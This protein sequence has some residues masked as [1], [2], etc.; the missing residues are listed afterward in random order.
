MG[1]KDFFFEKVDDNKQEQPQNTTPATGGAGKTSFTRRLPS[2]S[3]NNADSPTASVTNLMDNLLPS[4]KKPGSDID[5]SKFHAH[6]DQVLSTSG[7]TGPNYFTFGQM[8]T[9]MGDLPDSAKY[10]GAFGALRTQGLS[11]QTLIESANH[12]LNLLDQDNEN[13]RKRA[14]DTQKESKD[15]I[16][17]VNNLVSLNNQKIDKVKSD[18]ALQ[19]KQLEQMRDNQI[20]QLQKEIDDN[21]KKI[22][23]LEEE[24]SKMNDRITAFDSACKDYQSMISQDIQKIQSI[25]PN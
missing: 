3:N 25:I 1:L 21:K 20:Q 6:F 17:S 22:A 10:K 8:L 2:L 15:Q 19:I 4:V 9:E 13:F 23:P 16:Q 24:A 5:Q 14:L 11:K 7:G 18:I 12:F